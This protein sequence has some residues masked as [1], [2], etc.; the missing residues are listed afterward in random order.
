MVPELLLNI[1]SFL[2]GSSFVSASCVDKQWKSIFRGSDQFNARLNEHLH[3]RF[4]HLWGK[5]EEVSYVH[6]DDD[7]DDDDEDEDEDDE[8]VKWQRKRSLFVQNAPK[9]LRWDRQRR[10]VSEKLRPMSSSRAI[11]FSRWRFD[12]KIDVE[13]LE[14]FDVWEWHSLNSSLSALN[15][16]IFGLN[17][18]HRKWRSILDDFDFESDNRDEE[19][20]L[21]ARTIKTKSM[22]KCFSNCSTALA[23]CERQ[24]KEFVERKHEHE[25]RKR[26]KI[27]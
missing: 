27:E 25:P 14:Q 1:G 21:R 18:G 16:A 12:D 22:F 17:M 11:G 15:H 4:K 20:E 6:D 5:M 13:W 19:E 24:L 26:V 7:D 2:D 9:W 3:A 10:E 23:V 8:D